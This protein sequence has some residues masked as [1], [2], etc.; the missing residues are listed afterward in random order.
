M[1]YLSA[2]IIIIIITLENF[3]KN[4]DYSIILLEN[5]NLPP[6]N[7]RKDF[8]SELLKCT[9]FNQTEPSCWSIKNTNLTYL[10]VQLLYPISNYILFNHQVFINSYSH[11]K[12]LL[13]SFFLILE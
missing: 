9:C 6:K 8:F 11:P 12:F 3:F 1:H 5:S 4:S 7:F 13:F 10:S 2:L